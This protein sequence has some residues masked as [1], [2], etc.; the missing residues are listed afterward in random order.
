VKG[1]GEEG[2]EIGV[3]GGEE[4]G[5]HRRGGGEGCGAIRLRRGVSVKGKRSTRRGQSNGSL[6][7]SCQSSGSQQ[8]RV[9]WGAA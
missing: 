4:G 3:G 8:G 1:E 2:G 5:K 9:V 6:Y 7:L